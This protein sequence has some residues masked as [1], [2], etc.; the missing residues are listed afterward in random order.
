MATA[1]ALVKALTQRP[2]VR[3]KSVAVP[4]RS[5]V[6]Y[7]SIYVLVRLVISL[8]TFATSSDSVR[9]GRANREAKESSRA[10]QTLA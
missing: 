4:E 10:Y 1:A 7:A 8:A 6:L 2:Q 3:G 5:T 9:R